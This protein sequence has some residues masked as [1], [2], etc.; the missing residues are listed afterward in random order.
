ML[1][2]KTDTI[3][4]AFEDAKKRLPKAKKIVVTGTPTKVKP[5]NLSL[6]REKQIKQDIGLDISLPTVLVFGGSQGALA[7]N[8]ALEE[9]IKNKIPEKYQIIWAAGPS[10]YDIIKQHLEN[11]GLN[12]ESIKNVKIVPYIY[13]MDEVM[14]VCDIVIARSGAMTLTELA[15]LKKPSILIP[16]PSKAANRQEDNAR[17]LEKLDA[18][19]VILNN[20]LNSENLSKAI[21]DMLKNKEK[22]KQMGQNAGKIA[23]QNVEEKIYNEVK[24]LVPSMQ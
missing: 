15:I 23:I 7:I 5:M 6:E 2:K 8:N 1:S 3:L 11:E 24:K 13:N 22:L 17:V 20:E 14:S 10:Q 9:I 4:V 12:I 21:N 19:K 18:A 16:L